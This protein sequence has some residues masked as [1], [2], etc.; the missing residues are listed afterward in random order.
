MVKHLADR[1]ADQVQ[2]AT[3]AGPL[4]VIK[5]EASILAWHDEVKP[6]DLGLC[7]GEG[8]ALKVGTS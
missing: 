2:G 5:I 8:S 6:L 4:L 3:A 1:L 7:C